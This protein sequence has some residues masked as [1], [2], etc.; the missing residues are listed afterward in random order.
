MGGR[1]HRVTRLYRGSNIHTH[2]HTHR[3]T[4]HRTRP[5]TPTP[6]TNHRNGAKH[7]SDRTITV[8]RTRFTAY[9]CGVCFFFLFGCVAPVE[10]VVVGAKSSPDSNSMQRAQRTHK[11]THCIVT[12]FKSTTRFQRSAGGGVVQSIVKS[13]EPFSPRASLG[14]SAHSHRHAAMDTRAYSIA[15]NICIASP[16]QR[17]DTDT[18][19]CT[20]TQRTHN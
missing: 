15:H 17:I 9:T 18:H 6:T 20:I 3:L 14:T 11:H 16:P 12:R 13:D 7:A 8:Q 19:T 4:N 1:V 2:A 10:L 5:H